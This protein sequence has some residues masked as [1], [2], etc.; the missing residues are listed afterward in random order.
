MICSLQGIHISE[1]SAIATIDE[2]K[3][4]L[5]LTPEMFT[6]LNSDRYLPAPWLPGTDWQNMKCPRGRAHLPWGINYQD[7]DQAIKDGGPKQILTDEGMIEVPLENSVEQSINPN[8]QIFTCEKCGR[9]IKSRLAF[10][11]HV[12]ACKGQNA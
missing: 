1:D 12:K 4:K 10:S 5:P 8:L 11:N 2:S 6:S 7:I 3:L 9:Q